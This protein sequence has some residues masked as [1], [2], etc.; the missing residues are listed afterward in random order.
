ML[1]SWWLPLRVN[2][3][4]CTSLKP[5]TSE[6]ARRSQALFPREIN[7]FLSPTLD[8]ARTSV[9]F[10]PRRLASGKPRISA[11]KCGPR[12]ISSVLVQCLAWPFVICIPVL[13]HHVTSAIGPSTSIDRFSIFRS[14]SVLRYNRPTYLDRLVWPLVRPL[15]HRWELKHLQLAAETSR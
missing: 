3:R 13:C 7:R 15:R 14:L 1:L 5:T 9:L 11:A 6:N 2:E 8:E 12:D 4:C 10:N